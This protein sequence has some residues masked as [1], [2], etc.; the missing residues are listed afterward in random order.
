VPKSAIFAQIMNKYN[1]IST[2]LMLTILTLVFNACV[3]RKEVVYFNDLG[4]SQE[5]EKTKTT[6]IVIQPGDLL[7]IQVYS[8][9]VEAALPFNL[10]SQTNTTGGQMPSYTNGIAHK[11]GYPVD[12]AGKIYMPIVGEVDLKGK[13]LDS[14]NTIIENKLIPFLKVP[15]V[16]VRILNFR[17]TVLGDVRSP[18]TFNIPNEKLSLPEAL[19]IAGDMNISGVRKNVLIIREEEG[20]RKAYRVDLTSKQAFQSPAFYLKQNDIVYVEP[21]RAQRNSASINSRAGI[22]ISAISLIFSFFILI[23]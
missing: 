7:S 14:V 17:V 8:S 13:P 2:I 22:V 10:P 23:K 3:T 18:G 5:F 6:P 11:Q 21:N 20:E 9:D 12:N 15:V 16:Q 1:Q 19:G 4:A